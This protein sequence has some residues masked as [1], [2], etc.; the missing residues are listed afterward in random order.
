MD[1]VG[2]D[3][4]VAFDLGDF[5]PSRAV[6][7]TGEHAIVARCKRSQMVAGANPV[8]P[9]PCSHGLQK[10]ALQFA[11]RDRILRPFVTGGQ[12]TGLRPN[13]LPVLVEVGKLGGGDRMAR[14]LLA[15][16]EFGQLAHRMRLDVD[17]KS[18]KLERRRGFENIR[19]ESDLMQT[20]R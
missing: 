4:K 5:T 1:T 18:E 11:A 3:Q 20:E 14:E 9:K 2:A 17:S 19:I 10:Q 8:G 6:D 13:Q 16:T 7:E 15:E 12:A